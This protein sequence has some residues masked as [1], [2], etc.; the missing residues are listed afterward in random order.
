MRFGGTTFSQ[1]RFSAPMRMVIT[2]AIAF[3]GLTKPTMRSVCSIWVTVALASIAGCGDSVAPSV[4]ATDP[5]AV[6]RKL[7]ELRKGAHG[8]LDAAQSAQLNSCETRKQARAIDELRPVAAATLPHYVPEFRRTR[9]I[10]A[11]SP[12]PLRQHR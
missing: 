4:A 5:Q 1:S 2:A 12:P 11:L 7:E 8:D 6:C 3:A 10:A 9:P